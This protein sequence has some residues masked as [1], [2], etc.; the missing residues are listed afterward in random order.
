VE[1]KA[2]R[3]GARPFFD[4]RLSLGS[5]AAPCTLQSSLFTLGATQVRS[6][7]TETGLLLLLSPF[8]WAHASLLMALRQLGRIMDDMSRCGCEIKRG[9]ETRSPS[10]SRVRAQEMHH[11]MPTV[12]SDFIIHHTRTTTVYLLLYHSSLI[13]S[14]AQSSLRTRLSHST[15]PFICPAP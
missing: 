15:P 14:M 12:Y 4:G 5:S 2:G 9:G 6:K 10:S 7:P 8:R 3:E 13:H 1:S 11:G